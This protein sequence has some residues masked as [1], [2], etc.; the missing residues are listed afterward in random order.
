L[1]ITNTSNTV[2]QHGLSPRVLTGYTGDIRVHVHTNAACGTESACHTLNVATAGAPPP[3]CGGTTCAYTLRL[4]DSYGDGWN[5]A[6]M[7]I[8]E[9]TSVIATVG[10]TFTTGLGPV[11]VSVPNLCNGTAYNLYWSAGGS[12]PTEVG[13]QLIDPFGT[14]LYI[15]PPGTGSALTQLYAFSASC[16]PPTC[17]PVSGLSASNTGATSASVNWTCASCSGSFIVEYGAP[18]F[19]PGTG[20]TAGAGGT[21]ATTTAVAP[22][23]L[24]GLTGGS[25][26]TVAVRQNCGGTFSTNQTANFTTPPG[27]GSNFYDS[28]GPAGNYLNNE[29]QTITICPDVPGDVVT[30]TFSLVDFEACCDF[31]TVYDANTATGTPTAISTG[32]TPTFTANNPSGCLTFTWSSDISL[33]YQGWAAAVTCAPAPTCPTPTSGA[34]STITTNSAVANWTDNG[35]AGSFIVEYGPAATFTTPGTDATA[36]AGGTVITGA[37][38]PQAI[39]GLSPATQYRYF[40]RQDCAGNGFSTNSGA[41]LFTT[42]AEPPNCATA[43]TLACNTPEVMTIAPGTGVWNSAFCGFGVPGNEKVYKFVAPIA[44]TYQL[45]V[46]ATNSVYVDY[47]WKAEAGGTCD[48]TGWTCIDDII[49]ATTV[50]VTFPAAGTYW[51]LADPEG[52]AGASQTFQINCPCLPGAATAS[53]VDDC[54]NNQYSIDVN[55]TDIGSGATAGVR[56]S[57]N[58]G[59]NVDVTGLGLGVETIGPFTL[60]DVVAVTLLHGSDAQCNIVLGSYDSSCPIELECG[61][62]TTLNYC[63]KNNDTK[64]WTYTSPIVDET[65]TLTF[66]SGSIDEIGDVVRIYNG[67]DNSG[68][69]L[70]SSSVSDLTGITATSDMTN[71]IYMEVVSDG[72]NSCQDGNQTSWV[73][74]IECTPGCTDP[75]GSVTVTTDCP[76]YQFSMEVEVLG[77]GDATTTTLSY[78][79]NGGAPTL[80]PGLIEF[81]IENIGPFTVG[82]DVAV[83]LNHET[84]GGCNRNLGTFTDN[85]TCPPLSENCLGAQNLVSLPNPYSSTTVGYVDDLSSYPGGCQSN[86]SPDRVFYIDVPNGAQLTIGQTVNGYDSENYVGYG[87]ACPGTTQIACYDDPD[88]QNAVW[89]NTT[90]ST[91]RV[92][93][94]QDGY[95]NASNVG[96]FTLAWSLSGCAGPTGV[97]TSL[98]TSTQAQVNFTGVAGD[99]I[100]EYGPSATFTTPG[101]GATAGVGGTIITGTTSPIVIAGLSPT[102]SYVYYVRRDCGVDGFSSNTGAQFFTTLAPPPANDLCADAVAITC[103]SAIAGTTEAATTDTPPLTPFTGSGGPT[104]NNGV[105]YVYTGDDQNIT[106]STCSAGTL[107]DSRVNVYRTTAACTGFV[108]VAGNDDQ[109]TPGLCGPNG[110]QGEV[111]FDAL[112]GFLYYVVVDG[113]FG[114]Q[115]TFTV[116][117]T[118]NGPTCTP[119]PGNDDCVNAQP[120]TTGAFGSCTFTGGTTQCAAPTSGNPG[121]VSTFATFNDVYYSFVAGASSANVN[122]TNVTGTVSAWTVYDACGGTQVLCTTTTGSNV[123]VNGL[124]SGNTYVL[125][126]LTLASATFNVCVSNGPPPPANDACANAIA[127]GCNSQ[128]NGTTVLSAIDTEAGTCVTAL[129]TSGG[130]WYTVPGWDG[131]MTADLCTNGAFDSKIGVFTGSCGALTCVTGNDDFCGANAS[132]SWTGASGTTYYILV[133]GFGANTGTFT[134]TT[135]CGTNNAACTEN[136]LTMEFQTD[137]APFETTW[138]IRNTAGTVV[139]TS[140]GPLAAPFGVQTESGCVPDGCYTLR[141]LDAGGDGMTTGGYIL[142]TQGTNQRII[143]NRNNFSSGSVSAISGGQGFCLPISND[144]VLFTSCDKLDWINGQYVVAAPNAAVSAEWIVG[145]ANGVQ[146]ANSGYEFWIF[147]PN[148]S[149]SFRRFRSHNVSDGFGP[150]SATRACHMKLNNWGVSTQVPANVLMNVRVRARVNGLNGE[151]GPA[152][153]LAI[154]PVLAAC[155]QTN[156]MDV[157]GSAQF[158]CGVTRQYGPGNYVYARPVTGA[159]RYQFRFRI[160][161]EGYEVVRTTTSYTLQLNWALASGLP[162]QDGKT[163][164]VDVRVSKDAGATW[165]TNAAV[166]GN[167]CQVTIDQTPAGSGNQNFAAAGSNADLRMFPNPNRGDV[168]TFSLSAIEEGVN[169]VTVDIF[170]MFGKRVSARTIAVADGNVNTNIALNGE[171]AAGMY[172]VNIT[173]GEK[174]YTERLVIQP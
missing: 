95:F 166:W 148:G 104:I 118:C 96:T 25:N 98:V 54:G 3:P 156:L 160:V 43:P 120:L 58:G 115:G 168:L 80:V 65:V 161:A 85:G 138:E 163:Y 52:T 67:T 86:T 2:I 112:S 81:D 97:F 28:G 76:N 88:I 66:I 146:D 78:S 5:G 50:N 111:S 68:A 42:L 63:Y 39:G 64:T 21:V 77:V 132:V 103:G 152:C 169:T 87:G 59:A 117:T 55:I 6:T 26:Y 27:C 71:S 121:C 29:N 101:T 173:A 147:D 46:T 22:Y 159:N 105:W 9:G 157:P 165:C 74:E 61:T 45:A 48:A 91:Q 155:P 109:G 149:Y 69:L 116:T 83:F 133:T 92:Y 36:G 79:V 137:G 13:I 1:T 31:L 4:T 37:V 94:V 108:A 24:T 18:G 8:R 44:G 14:S 172:L 70:A 89:T 23:A 38:S 126:V 100:V 167:V 162:L 145:G 136:G 72:S 130:V 124:T 51:I 40:V 73:V 47:A 153:R 140:G 129:T 106:V 123:T 57:V 119:L 90:G 33:A 122:V 15:K 113:Y 32:S 139:A 75:D 171:L 102:T 17:A 170:D 174:T 82:D 158:S 142:R 62:T 135:R 114:A 151:F 49:F 34:A 128:T 7:Q 12:Y 11:D 154:N 107:T 41:Q 99:Y 131:P 60:S 10:G 19:T 30:V 144:A 125:R 56:Y 84:D 53:V 35:G 141:V 134:L 93:W 127:I 164:D 20:L 110:F 16:T 143:D 150:A